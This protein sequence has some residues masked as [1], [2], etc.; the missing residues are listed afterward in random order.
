[1]A[2]VKTKTVP[3]RRPSARESWK[4]LESSF[5][6][7]EKIRRVLSTAR[8]KRWLYRRRSTPFRCVPAGLPGRCPPCARHHGTWQGK[9]LEF[10][11][12]KLDQKRK[13]RCRFPVVPSSKAEN[14]AGAREKHLLET[15]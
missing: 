11:V 10:K 7:A 14:S 6:H 1:M 2:S 9:E 4:V 3:V 15:L 12:I 8:F 13:Q 5:P